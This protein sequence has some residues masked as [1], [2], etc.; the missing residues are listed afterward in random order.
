MRTQSTSASAA[1]AKSRLNGAAH[2]KAKATAK[3]IHEELKAQ[4]AQFEDDY[5][6]SSP[7]RVLMAWVTGL[8]AACA[9]AYGWNLAIDFVTVAAF[10]ITG[11][12]FLAMAIYVIGLLI[13]IY[14]SVVAFSSAFAY[15]VSS[16]PEQHIALVKG[17]VLSMTAKVRGMFSRSESEVIIGE[18]KVYGGAA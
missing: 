4:A 15:V 8:G 10:S 7:R 5:E 2:P 16:K 3:P 13:A 14:S 12:S 1:T 11:S 6:H 9:S 17:G 18:G